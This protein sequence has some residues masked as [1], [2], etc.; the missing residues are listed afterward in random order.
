MTERLFPIMPALQDLRDLS[1]IRRA[2]CEAIVIGIPWDLIAP[3]ERQAQS[4]H[5]QSLERLAERGGLAAVEAVNIMTGARWGTRIPAAEANTRLAEM[6]RLW[7]A[8]RVEQAD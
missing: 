5:G 6:V 7:R 8:K 3:H 1:A 2:G 4:N